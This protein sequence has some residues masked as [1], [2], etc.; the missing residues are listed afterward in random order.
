MVLDIITATTLCPAII[1]TKL[2]IEGGSRRNWR[3]GNKSLHLEV[4]VKFQGVGGYKRKFEGAR[5]VLMGGKLYIEHAD[6]HFDPE[7]IQ[8]LLGRFQPSR[9]HQDVWDKTGHKGDL[10]TSPA[11]TSS[12]SSSSPSLTPST[13]PDDPPSYVYVDHNTHELK[14]GSTASSDTHLPGPWST[15]DVQKWLL[16]EGWEGWVVVQ[17]DAERDLW[18]LYFDRSDDGL[19]GEGKVGDVE[20]GRGKGRRMLYVRLIRKEPTRT[21]GKQREDEE[22]GRRREEEMED[23]RSCL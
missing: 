22:E 13:S 2:S 20:R 3:D 19:T 4:F 12:S 17:E 9:E 8:P 18:A 23:D 10:F 5:V 6:S 14:Y 1:A 7:S 15:T 21:L 16:F 11:P